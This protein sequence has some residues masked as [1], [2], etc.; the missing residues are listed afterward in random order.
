MPSA[1]AIHGLDS[2]AQLLTG[3]RNE[4]GEAWRVFVFDT[5]TKQL[6]KR[7]RVESVQSWGGSGAKIRDHRPVT[8]CD[9][10]HFVEGLRLYQETTNTG[11]KQHMS[12]K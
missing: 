6:H 1:N 12:P 8:S 5:C 10:T 7:L 9:G 11:K 4:R 2:I 3:T